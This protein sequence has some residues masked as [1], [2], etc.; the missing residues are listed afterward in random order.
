MAGDFVEGVQAKL[1]ERRPP[2]WEPTNLSE[3]AAKSVEKLLSSNEAL[4]EGFVLETVGGSSQGRA[5]F[6]L[7]NEEFVKDVLKRLSERN[8]RNGALNE[9]A[10]LD[11]MEIELRGKHG[12]RDRV[13]EILRRKTKEGLVWKK[14]LMPL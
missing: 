10:V 4:P 14:T 12:V 1:V 11:E 13:L 3:V 2:I 8:K 9:R 7:P 6:G 5:S